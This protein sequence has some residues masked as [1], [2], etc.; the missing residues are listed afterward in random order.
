M[1][2]ILVLYI[3]LVIIVIGLAVV[4]FTGISEILP[5]GGNNS[6][7]TVINN[8]S[9]KTEVAKDEE[10]KQ[11]GL[12]KRDSLDQDQALLFVFD[13]KAKHSFW[14]YD[15]RFPIDIIFIEKTSPD[16]ISEGVIVDIIEDAKVPAEN[17]PRS[18]L[19]IYTPEKEADLVLEI[20]SGISKEKEFKVGD[21]VIFENVQ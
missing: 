20:N 18:A 9:F 16:S 2:K 17:T 5:G 1:K 19:E 13:T 21:T 8:N 4:K 7:T 14:M 15:M 12:S 3:F 6:A 11:K 10:S